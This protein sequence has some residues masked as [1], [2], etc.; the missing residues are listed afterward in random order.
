MFILQLLL[1][2][3]FPGFFLWRCL[4]TAS[5]ESPL[6]PPSLGLFTHNVE[7]TQGENMLAKVVKFRERCKKSTWKYCTRNENNLLFY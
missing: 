4:L 3:A 7:Q 5:L 2:R 1:D 6:V